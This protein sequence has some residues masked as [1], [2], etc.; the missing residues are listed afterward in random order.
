MSWAHADG[1]VA[2]AVSTSPVGV[3]VA[4]I[5]EVGPPI[6]PRVGGASG[7]VRWTRTEALVKRGDGEL[8]ALRQWPLGSE[9]AAQGITLRTLVA[10]APTDGV[11]TDLV[12]D[13]GRWIVSV[14][15]DQVAHVWDPRGSL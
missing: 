15:A 6:R 11:L 13:G 10:T 12:D 3:D 14:A 7:W 4:W 2:A 8:F 5:D 9:P 1:L